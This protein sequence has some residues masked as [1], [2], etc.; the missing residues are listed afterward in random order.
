MNPHLVDVWHV[1]TSLLHYYRQFDNLL[2]FNNFAHSELWRL[3]GFFIGWTLKCASVCVC[4]CVW[5][6]YKS[7]RLS[8]A[9]IRNLENTLSLQFL[10]T[11]ECIR[12]FVRLFFLIFF[13]YTTRSIKGLKSAYCFSSST[14]NTTVSSLLYLPF[15]LLS[16]TPKAFLLLKQLGVSLLFYSSETQQVHIHRKGHPMM[17]C[18][19]QT[20]TRKSLYATSAGSSCAGGLRNVTQS[21]L[22]STALPV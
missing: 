15:R 20:E 12:V 9:K 10:S 6:N 14:W 11:F 16:Y 22:R 17:S 8:P 18:K 7:S 5:L 21:F 19:T 4:V 2:Y 1:D 13:F 3:E